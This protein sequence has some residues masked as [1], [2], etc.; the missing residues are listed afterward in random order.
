[1]LNRRSNDNSVLWIAM[2]FWQINRPCSNGWCNW[3]QLNA[4]MAQCFFKP[5]RWLTWQDDALMP[6]K[7]SNLKTANCWYSNCHCAWDLFLS[8]FPKWLVIFVY[9][10]KP[11]MRIQDKARAKSKCNILSWKNVALR[12]RARRASKP[13]MSGWNPTYNAALIVVISSMQH[14]TLH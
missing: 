10:P 8:D 6:F 7:P 11:D 12:F 13:D 2:M 14:A 4:R 5:F 1:M 3:K 9:P